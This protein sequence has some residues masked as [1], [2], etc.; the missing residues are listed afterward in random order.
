MKY[1]GQ[2]PEWGITQAKEYNEKHYHQPSDEFHADW[3]FSGMADMAR[4]GFE[5]GWKA[6]NQPQEIHW[7]KGD[8]FEA[9]RKSSQNAAERSGQQ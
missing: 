6:A 3:D 9:A 7:Q 1:K 5:L 8:E 4:F 2:P